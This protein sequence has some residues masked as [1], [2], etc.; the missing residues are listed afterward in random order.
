MLSR[1]PW[2]RV[3]WGKS[4]AVPWAKLHSEVVGM[5]PQAM[6][7]FVCIV[8]LNFLGL[9][10]A[11]LSTQRYTETEG[12]A[13]RNHKMPTERFWRNNLDLFLHIRPQDIS[14]FCAIGRWR[15]L[16]SSLGTRFSPGSP[17]AIMA[18]SKLLLCTDTTDSYLYE[19][20]AFGS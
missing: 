11:A 20:P 10:P 19:P 5:C 18:F 6:A 9:N 8:Q 7:L 2:L 13:E 17:G 16:L 15:L 3:V 14:S 1:S 12:N 4:R